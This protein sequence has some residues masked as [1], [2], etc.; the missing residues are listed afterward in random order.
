MTGSRLTIWP[1]SSSHQSAFGCMLTSPRPNRFQ[2]SHGAPCADIYRDMRQH[3]GQAD[4]LIVARRI[5]PAERQTR[6]LEGP[7][8][9]NRRHSRGSES[10]GRQSRPMRAAVQRAQPFSALLINQKIFSLGQDNRSTHAP[11]DS[12]GRSE[13]SKLNLNRQTW[14]SI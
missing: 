11:V 14:P 2:S 5:N 13:K 3:E 8:G 10:T 7:S 1:S 9:H 6:E 4:D 12:T